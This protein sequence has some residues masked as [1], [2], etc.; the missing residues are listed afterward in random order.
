VKDWYEGLEGRCDPY[1]VFP[2]RPHACR[3]RLARGLPPPDRRA[4]AK[5]AE[6]FLG[7]WQQDVLFKPEHKR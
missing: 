4:A 1:A 5:A 3:Y 6:R 7:A 2:E